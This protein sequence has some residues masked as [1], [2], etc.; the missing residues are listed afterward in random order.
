MFLAQFLLFFDFKLFFVRYFIILHNVLN[1]E[2]H[3]TKQKSQHNFCQTSETSFYDEN[4]NSC[5]I[6]A[7]NEFRNEEMISYT[8]YLI[9]YQ[10]DTGSFTYSDPWLD[11]EKSNNNSISNEIHVNEQSQVE[12]KDNELSPNFVA[13]N[14]ISSTHI[15]QNDTVERIDEHK[16]QEE[17]KVSGQLP[18][19]T[20]L[21]NQL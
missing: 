21:Q 8:P 1:H 9:T 3:K 12:T 19:K 7:S 11:L 13:E 18:V 15:T 17:Q 14:E 2:S 20:K 6:E 16:Q 5:S 4:A 10:E